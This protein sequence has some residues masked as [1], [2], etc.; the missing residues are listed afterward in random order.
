MGKILKKYT[1][2]PMSLYVTREA[3]KQL[4]QIIEDMQRPGYV[5]VARQMGKTNLLFHAKRTLESADRL[6]IYVDLSNHFST[7][8]ECYR[9]IVD[10]I[11]EPNLHI[12]ESLLPKI[13]S[14]RQK[15]IPPHKEY[16]A[17][18][19][20]ILN[21]FLGNMIIILDE[22]DALRNATYSDNVFA[23]IRSNYFSRT[24][25][26]V[27]ER[28]TY[29]LS[30]VIEP[31]DLIKDRNKSPFN[32]GEKIYLD[33]FSF[34]EYQ[35]FISQSKLNINESMIHEIYNWT[36]GNPRLT[37]DICSEI[38]DKLIEGSEITKSSITE[39]VNNKFLISYDI[40][41]VDH[42]RELVKSNKAIRDA[43]L[44]IHKGDCSE[45]SDE[46]KNKLYLYGITSS[47]FESKTTIKNPII[48]KA[49][50]EDWI[51][52]IDKQAKSSLNYGIDKIIDSDFDAGIILIKKFLEN[53]KVSKTD[54]QTSNYFLGFAFYNK[55]DFDESI[56][57]LSKEFSSPIFQRN[58][59]S[60][61]G[62]CYLLTNRISDGERLVNKVLEAPQNDFA[63]RNAC[64]NY[65]NFVKDKNPNL[66]L[67]KF[68]DLTTITHEPSEDDFSELE[69]KDLLTTTNFYIAE[70]YAD[71]NDLESSTTYVNKALATS[72][73]NNRL[74]LDYFL[75]V[76]S[77]KD[78]NDLKKHIVQS[79]MTN[80]LEMN[81]RN[82]LPCNFNTNHLLHYLDFIFNQKNNKDYIILF[83]YA[84][85]NYFTNMSELDLS[86]KLDSNSNSNNNHFKYY[87]KHNKVK[88]SE[89]LTYLR[90]ILVSSIN[91]GHFL[92]FESYF[93]D[94][95]NLL[96]K[97]QIL[98][99]N[100]P[101]ILASMLSRLFAK[102]EFDKCFALCSF[103]KGLL[104]NPN[105]TS[106]TLNVQNVYIYYWFSKIYF[107]KGD[108]V[109]T[110][111]YA[112]LAIN[113]LKTN[114][115][116]NLINKKTQE[117]ILSDM[118]SIKE[119]AQLLKIK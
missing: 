79:I 61:L 63:Y 13:E 9:N 77:G 22:I 89:K 119:V 116:D 112:D 117:R 16:E 68:Q 99:E 98:E 86:V 17:S 59:E 84:L 106:N 64:L 45:L 12:F 78:T 7:D 26:P 38:E 46:I 3:D 118:E 75:G 57:Y 62:I 101:Y 34:T 23:Q 88:N 115:Q 72:N 50:S 20:L 36:K 30:G 48:S 91:K 76:I 4:K 39:L 2:I 15:E 41:P 28:L 25:F 81:K 110:I 92:K 94:F 5:L 49:L 55:Q 31:T 93:D 11:T 44:D 109:Q 96:S 18:L 6:F 113:T 54:L 82:N 35:S 100:D 14:I 103:I 65:A 19:R 90:T 85:E 32:I 104:L 97:N 33:D 43:I 69:K 24:N 53:T 67:Q 47:N 114:R 52:S 58:S 73:I 95:K 70:I 87:I 66:A 40:P 105:L 107:K 111:Q 8:R 37:F 27:F 83:K 108:T 60:M 51:Y 29:I 10:S 42:I 80:K 56:E 1:T 74:F 71:K 21:M 102:H